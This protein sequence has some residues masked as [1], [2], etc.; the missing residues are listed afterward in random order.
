MRQ[1]MIR[2]QEIAHEQVLA[3]EKDTA[4]GVIQKSARRRLE[5]MAVQKEKDRVAAATDLQ[6]IIRGYAVCR[7]LAKVE[8]ASRKKDDAVK[9][10]QGGMEDTKGNSRLKHI[11]VREAW[12]KEMRDRGLVIPEHVGTDDNLADLFTKPLPAPKLRAHTQ[13]IMRI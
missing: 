5:M 13:R 10:P 11:D 3:V 8:A 6:R 4:A 1:H 9:D 2:Q 7:K 12:V